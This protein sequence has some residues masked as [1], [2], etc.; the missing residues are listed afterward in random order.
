MSK[1]LEEYEILLKKYYALQQLINEEFIEALEDLE[2]SISHTESS[3][4]YIKCQKVIRTKMNR[5]LHEY[6]VIYDF[7]YNN[8][9][10]SQLKK[11]INCLT[12]ELVMLNQQALCL[13]KN[14]EK[15]LK[16]SQKINAKLSRLKQEYDTCIQP[17]CGFDSPHHDYDD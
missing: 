8:P 10:C 15:L 3:L 6:G 1:G 11:D 9:R 14:S 16:K 4:N 12:T 2:S 5:W 7:D 13:S 17:S